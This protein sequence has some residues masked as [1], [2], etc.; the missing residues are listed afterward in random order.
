L[1]PRLIF[2]VPLKS[3]FKEYGE[4]LYWCFKKIQEGVLNNDHFLPLYTDLFS[5]DLTDYSD[6]KI[7]DLG[8]GPRGSLEWA[9]STLERVG[10]DPLTKNY[11]TLGISSHEMTYVK[12]YAEEIPF[13]KDYFDVISSFNNLDHVNNLEKTCSEITRVL[14]PGGL[15]LLIAEIHKK[16]QITEPQT[17][18]WSL[19]KE[20]FSDFDILQEGHYQMVHRNRIYQNCFKAIPVKNHKNQR[21]IIVAKLRKK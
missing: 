11:R 20:Y 5:K 9:S 8:C 19:L 4:F 1:S 21:G 2:T 6:Q 7:L 18:K 3:I 14:K 12:G 13:D 16:P 10:L 15:F 17:L